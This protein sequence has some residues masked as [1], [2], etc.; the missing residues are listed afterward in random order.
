MPTPFSGD[1]PPPLVRIHDSFKFIS[2]PCSYE[3]I[4]FIHQDLYPAYPDDAE[5]S[6]SSHNGQDDPKGNDDG[7]QGAPS[8]EPTAP[9][10]NMSGMAAQVRSSIADQLT[11]AT[12]L[13]SDPLKKKH[14]VLALKRK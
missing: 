14:L 9:N 5:L 2:D 11:T 13:G 3:S 4:L 6:D 7:G 1:N 12:P 10:L 8:S